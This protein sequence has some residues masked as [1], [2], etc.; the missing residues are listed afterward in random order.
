MRLYFLISILSISCLVSLSQATKKPV[1]KQSSSTQSQIDKAMEEAMKDMS[2]EEKAEM[3]KL[4][5]DAMKT[6]DEMKN[7][8]VKGNS[9]NTIPKIPIKQTLLLQQIPLLQTQQQLNAYYLK[10]FTEC[11]KNIPA[12]IMTKV[13]QM[14]SA[15]AANENEIARLPIFLFLSKNR[16]AAVYAAVKVLQLKGNHPLVQNNSAFVLAQSGYPGKAVPVFKYLQQKYNTAELNNNLAQSYLSLG[17]KEEAKKYFRIGLAKNPESSEMHCGLALILSEEGNEHPDSYRE[18]TLHIKE[19]LAHGYSP[20]AEALASKHKVKLKFSDIRTKAPEYFNP[21]KFKPAAPA[22]VMED[23]PMV[24]AEREAVID[25]HRNSH[26]KV[27]SFNAKYSASVNEK[28]MQSVMQQHIGY[29][30]SS[31]FSRKAIFMVHLINVERY[32]FLANN[33]DL[34]AYKKIHDE[35]RKAFDTRFESIQK[36]A[37]DNEAKRCEAHVNNLNNFLQLSKEN[38]ENY[39][40]HVLPKIYDYTNQSLYWQ[41]FLLSGDAYKAYFY[42]EVNEFYGQLIKFNELQN[43]YPTP[44]WIFNSCKNYKKDLDSIKLE[45]IQ[46]QLSCPIN[47]KIPP[48]G[49]TTVKINCKTMEVETEILEVLKLGYEKDLKTGEFSLAFG[50]GADINMDLLSIGAKGQMYFKFDRDFS[51]IDMGLK[52]E[53]GIESKT[54]LTIE[55]KITGTMGISSINVDAV[56]LGKEINLF[57]VDATK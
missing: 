26:K 21:Q 31:P 34:V 42:A 51:P 15:Q 10:L 52:G 36:T 1:K 18:A 24:Q 40:R 20:I 39:E 11:K 49:P 57:N 14:I 23:I 44:E 7:S 5:G 30:G 19:S 54:I 46:E 3:R 12:D 27:E 47:L 55:E 2:E 17:E 22:S 25:R 9:G 48:I 41:S 56:H 4:M 38:F 8:G 35:Y 53:A 50:L 13:D 6:A 28:N 37:F 16:K 33:M 43:V 29:T 45:E 32:E